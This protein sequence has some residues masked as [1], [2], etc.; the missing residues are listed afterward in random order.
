MVCCVQVVGDGRQA[1]LSDKASLPYLQAT[2]SEVQRI[3]STGERLFE[4]QINDAL[5]YAVTRV[6]RSRV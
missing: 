1:A 2:I 3:A 5:I 4:C 6:N